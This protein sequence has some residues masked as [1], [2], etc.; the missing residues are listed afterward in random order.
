MWASRRA[1]VP[2]YSPGRR[3]KK[4][5]MIKHEADARA[6]GAAS[7]CASAHTWATTGKGNGLT[8][9]GG[10]SAFFHAARSEARRYSTFPWVFSRGSGAPNRACA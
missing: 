4:K 7:P 2:K 5:P 3:R 10:A 1:G 9:R 6:K 8:R